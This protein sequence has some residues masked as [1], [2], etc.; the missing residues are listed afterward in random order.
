LLAGK[1]MLMTCY[2]ALDFNAVNLFD[3]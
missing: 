2:Q 1:M 3:K